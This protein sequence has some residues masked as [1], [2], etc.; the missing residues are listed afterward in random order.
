MTNRKSDKNVKKNE[1]NQHETEGTTMNQLR[2]VIFTER[3]QYWA[4]FDGVFQPMETEMTGYLH[5]FG[6]YP[7]FDQNAG[8]Y[9]DQQLAIVEDVKTGKF[10]QVLPECLNSLT[11]LE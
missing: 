5:G 8:R 10:Y 4:T 1:E 2:K 11:P 9:V 6:N 7:F 3:P